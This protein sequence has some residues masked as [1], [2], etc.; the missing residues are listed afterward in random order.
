M[1]ERL[2]SLVGIAVIV[3]IAILLSEHRRSI[4]PRVVFWGLGLQLL[5]GVLI[6]ASF[7]LPEAGI[8]GPLA[9]AEVAPGRWLFSVL[10]DGINGLL[11]FTDEGSSF[12]FG[13]LADSDAI[14]FVFAIKV[15][16]TI[17]F[18]S[19]IMA[20][21]YHLGI[22]QRVIELFAKL[23]RRTM[24]TSGAET[25]SVSAN[26]FVGQTEAP[27]VVRPFVQNM[28]RSELMAVMTGGFAT[29][30]GGVMA[31]YVGFGVDAGHVLTAS[32]ISAPAAMLMAKLFV[33]ERDTPATSGGAKIE[34][35][36]DTANVIEAAAGGAGDGLKLALNVGAMLLAFIALVAMLDFAL[37]ALPGDLSIGRIL[38][39][40]FLPLA[41]VLGVPSQD[42]MDV[43][44]LMGLKVA[45]NEFVAI[46]ELR[47]LRDAITPRSFV[48]ATFALCGFAN[49]SSIAIQIGGIGS[50]APSRRGDLAKLGLRAMFAG[51]LATWLTAAV[52]ALLIDNREAWDRYLD[53]VEERIERQLSPDTRVDPPI[54]FDLISRQL[55][56]ARADLS[57]DGRR[58]DD[59]RARRLDRMQAALEM[60]ADRARDAAEATAAELIEAGR[61]AEAQDALSTIADRLPE[62]D[63]APLGARADELAR[64]VSAVEDAEA[65]LEEARLL[66]VRGDEAARHY[67]TAAERFEAAAPTLGDRALSD[68]AAHRAAAI[69]EFLALVT[70]SQKLVDEDRG[71]ELRE[72]LDDYEVRLPTL[73]AHLREERIRAR[74]IAP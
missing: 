27:L 41:F 57:T 19:S 56:R 73:E 9:G 25:L 38:G 5:L 2:T 17:V 37:G 36:K 32:V 48:I 23:I 55:E 1:L 40:L 49:F 42:A 34:V 31:A 61:Y 21:L 30:A 35:E 16:P 47:E 59:E 28:T 15:L 39:W 63:A 71:A 13:P 24:G 45:L 26:I 64:L 3:A 65:R 33:P 68:A 67:K 72:T 44:M 60:A 22:M 29:V 43:G 62:Q 12:L 18:F 4:Q 8:F 50:I 7:R 58:G 66:G 14:G 74:A 10:R 46:V 53:D 11:E 20:I 70:E 52:A 54:P 6:L 69:R 51:A